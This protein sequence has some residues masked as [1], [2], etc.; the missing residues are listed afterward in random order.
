M[1][2]LALGLLVTVK[3]NENI[4]AHTHTS[5]FTALFSVTKKVRRTQITL[6]WAIDKQNTVFCTI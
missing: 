1:Y 5:L 2:D 6:N 3:R 4:C